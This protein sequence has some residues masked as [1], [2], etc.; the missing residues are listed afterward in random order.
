MLVIW[1]RV[2]MATP[3]LAFRHR[4]NSSGN[5]RT[6][7]GGKSSLFVYLPKMTRNSKRLISS[8]YCTGHIG[9]YQ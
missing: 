6:G 9:R 2:R 4:G 5:T 3:V 8:W 7:A 1:G